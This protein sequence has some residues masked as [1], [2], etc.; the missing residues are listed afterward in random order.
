MAKETSEISGQTFNA[1][2]AISYIVV[3][4]EGLK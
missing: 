4:T 1:S 2:L 3:C